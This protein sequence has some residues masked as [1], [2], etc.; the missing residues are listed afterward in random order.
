M[1]QT[2]TKEDGT[3]VTVYSEEELKAQRD[4][5]AAAAVAPIQ[6]E[7]EKAKADLAKANDKDANFAILR[8]KVT[9]LEGK[10]DTARADALREFEDNNRQRMATQAIM[11]LADGDAE[12][13]K[14]IEFNYKRLVGAGLK[15]DEEV[16]KAVLD[17]FTLARQGEAKPDEIARG[18]GPAGGGAPAQSPRAAGATQPLTENQMNFLKAAYPD[19]TDE[20]ITELRTQ[21]KPPK[22]GTLDGSFG[23][24]VV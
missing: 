24:I 17:A 15:T 4:E 19:L 7:L 5:A 22:V 6:T 16:K 10:M 23:K 9:T 14:K 21:A 1:P 11:S 3:E 20:K 2:I 18:F 8:E 12:M 13:Q